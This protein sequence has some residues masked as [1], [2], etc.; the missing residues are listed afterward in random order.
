M[1]ALTSTQHFK[2]DNFLNT[3]KISPLVFSPWKLMNIML[4]K[5][6]N[7]EEKFAEFFFFHNEKIKPARAKLLNFL[8]IFPVQ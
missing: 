5:L 4:I 8:K 6:I 3:Q 1:H 7:S 2:C